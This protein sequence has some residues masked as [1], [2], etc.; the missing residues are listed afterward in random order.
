MSVSPERIT[1]RLEEPTGVRRERWPVSRGIPFPPGALDTCDHLRLLDENDRELPLQVKGLSKWAD[2]SV[3]WALLLFQADLEP[4]REVRYNLQYGPDV[5]R[6]AVPAGC[7]CARE[8]AE[9]LAQREEGGPDRKD[10]S[11]VGGFGR[12]CAR[13][14]VGTRAGVE[15]D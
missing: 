2:G 14:R 8:A 7:D 3:R 1:L 5:E 12:E 11:D 9:A 10:E 15:E 13:T 4:Q 6:T